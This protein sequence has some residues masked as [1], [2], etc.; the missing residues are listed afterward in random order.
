LTEASTT[1]RPVRERRIPVFVL[2]GF[3]G[4]GKTTLLSGLIRSPA[5]A[6]T[7]VVI[8]EFGE[9]GLDHQLVE[10]SDEQTVLMESGCVCCTMRSDLAQTL[11][12]VALRIAH[13]ELPPISRVVLETTGLA[14][15]GPVLQT[16]AG[17]AMVAATFRL[18]GVWTTLDAVHA[19]SSLDRYPESLRQVAMADLLLLTKTDLVEA[20]ALPAVKSRVRRLN[21]DA[22]LIDVRAGHDLPTLLTGPDVE[23]GRA[24]TPFQAG[25]DHG[26]HHAHHH[27]DDHIRS[28]S[29]SY[30]AR[31]PLRA[32]ASFLEDLARDY[33]E[34]ILRIKGVI[35]ILEREAPVAIHGVQH[36]LH[37][38]VPLQKWAS[39]DQISQLVFIV[40][41]LPL[42]L[43]RS[44]FE[45]WLQLTNKTNTLQ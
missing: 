3:L 8:N 16:L 44:R 13:G 2:T 38:P 29:L 42:E 23:H 5:M 22:R 9:V 18:G 45:A 19:A 26:D 21:Q 17:D 39:D 30:S 28:L 40:D 7:L 14:D 24:V 32:V 25:E 4:S 34:K 41:D 37:P 35:G 33:G 10:S 1:K 6:G 20:D 15:P 36:M 43:I 11:G 27:H 12:D 31:L